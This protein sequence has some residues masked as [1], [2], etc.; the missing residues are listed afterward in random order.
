V[1]IAVGEIQPHLTEL[2]SEMPDEDERK[3]VRID[4]L[5]A[6]QRF[7]SA[8]RRAIARRVPDDALAVPPMLVDRVREG[9]YRLLVAAGET[10]VRS[11]QAQDK[12]EPM[13]RA[14]LEHA[15]A[16]LGR[17]G[18]AAGTETSEAIE[19]GIAEHGLTL[20]AA[21]ETVIPLLTGRLDSLDPADATRPRHADE[22]RLLGQFAL[23]ARRVIASA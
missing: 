10:I 8:A 23:Q 2:L 19:L 17:V 5:H 16:L 11:A 15:W 18:W 13:S 4:E 20:R 6:V 7:E 21:L 3:P 9:A 22:L 1:L 12:P 14:Q